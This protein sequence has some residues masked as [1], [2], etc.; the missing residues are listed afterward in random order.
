VCCHLGGWAANFKSTLCYMTHW[1]QQYATLR[2]KHSCL[3]PLLFLHDA[4]FANSRKQRWEMTLE[5]IK[6][7]VWVVSVYL[8]AVTAVS[9]PKCNVVTQTSWSEMNKK[10][11]CNICGSLSSTAKGICL[12]IP[13]I[14][15]GGSQHLIKK[16]V[17]QILIPIIIVTVQMYFY[18]EHK[19][20]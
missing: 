20:L 2:T 3:L 9:A 15:V 17:C 12:I 13:R 16:E 11:W 19:S 6:M 4:C 1:G 5:A 14:L 18:P 8:Y 7:L 10:S